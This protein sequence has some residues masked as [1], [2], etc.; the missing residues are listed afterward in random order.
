MGFLKRVLGGGESPEPGPDWARPMSGAEAIAFLE[1]VGTDIER[2]ALPF[3]IG[4]GVVRIQRGGESRDYGL[5]NLAQVCHRVGRNEW[6]RTIAGHFDSMLAAEDAQAQLDERA[7]DFESIRSIL[8]VRFF[9]DASVG[10]IYPERPASWQ[11]APGLVA[12][13]VY[14]LPTTV[15]SVNA[16]HIAGWGRGHDELLHV[17]IENVRGDTIDPRPIAD[18]GPS[19][20]MA[21]VADHFF[22]AS[23]AFLLGEYLP[24]GATHGAVFSVPHRHALLYAPILDL[25]VAQSI[26][27]L[28]VSGGSLFNQGPGSI[29][30]NLYWWRA[31]S[32][33]LLPAE[34]DE[35]RVQFAPPDEFV[36]ILNGL[37]PPG[38][39]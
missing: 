8:K 24:A 21:G 39:D 9:P 35:R 34:V 13:F 17:A 6:T 7:R 10:G 5:T 4:E 30:P 26:N 36:Q 1:A 3:A 11:V 14:D 2:R 31:G 29:S 12:S 28:I 20:A 18:D 38:A 32:V 22:V 15:A 16:S 37:G 27:R 23:H 33:S 25:G 19:S